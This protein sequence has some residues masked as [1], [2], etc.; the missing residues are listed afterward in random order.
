MLEPKQDTIVCA[1]CGSEEKEG[2][3]ARQYLYR[4]V[5][6]VTVGKNYVGYTCNN[7][8]YENLQY[9]NKEEKAY[10]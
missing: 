1:E 8:G 9:S 5:M 3:I 10:A 7:C 2:N 4:R 6:E